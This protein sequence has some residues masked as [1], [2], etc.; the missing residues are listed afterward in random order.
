MIKVVR[1]NKQNRYVSYL[2]IKSTPSYILWEVEVSR[3]C[4]VKWEISAYLPLG[5]I[6]LREYLRSIMSCRIQDGKQLGGV[7]SRMCL[8]LR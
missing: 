2:E 7:K 6:D 8:I 5:M 4:E 1:L 3:K